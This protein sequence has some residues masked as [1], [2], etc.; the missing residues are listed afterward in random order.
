MYLH[1][2]IRAY[3]QGTNALINQ[4]AIL[5]EGTTS[6]YQAMHHNC[7]NSHPAT[8]QT[9]SKYRASVKKNIIN[10]PKKIVYPLT[11][12][13]MRTFAVISIANSTNRARMSGI[14]QAS[15]WWL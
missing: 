13:K 7:K 14:N 11:K 9:N 5:I 6:I 1:G 12:C 2:P 3:S 10:L 4:G 8:K 15:A